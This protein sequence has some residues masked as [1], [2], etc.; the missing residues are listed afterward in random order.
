MKEIATRILT[1]KH[2]RLLLSKPVFKLYE[3]VSI[4]ELT[5]IEKRLNIYF[6]PALRAWYLRAGFGDIDDVLSFRKEWLSVI[7]R[8]ALK[9]HVIFAQDDLG[10]FFSFSP[11]DGQIHYLCCST[12]EYGLIASDFAA[13][14]DEFVSRSYQL[15]GWVGS[16]N[17]TH[18][19]WGV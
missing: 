1:A 16:I 13:F 14:L 3:S 12:P 4:T 8:G 11:E 17:T 2:K 10:N 18:Y 19:D 7:D 9:D 6:P 5:D 15:E